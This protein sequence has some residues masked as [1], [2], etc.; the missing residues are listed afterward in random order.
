MIGA[1]LDWFLGLF[2]SVPQN[3]SPAFSAESSGGRLRSVLLFGMKKRGQDQYGSGSFGALRDG[4]KRKH[5]GVDYESRAGDLVMSPMAGTLTREFQVYKDDSRYR[6]IEI[7]ND[8]G[9][10]VVKIFYVTAQGKIP[11]VVRAGDG[12]GF[13]QNLSPKYAGITNH[14]HI[15]L[16]V[17]GQ[18]ENVETWFRN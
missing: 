14:I 13:A 16:R 10:H 5:E 7:K 9:T 8:K 12:I 4:G 6:G 11:R 3:T 18:L 15:E 2:R 1:L 17:N